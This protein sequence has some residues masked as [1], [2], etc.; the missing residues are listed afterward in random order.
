VIGGL[1]REDASDIQ[2]KP[3]VL[4]DLPLIGWMFQ[5][6][7]NKKDRS[8]IVIALIPRIVPFDPHYDDKNRN[9]YKRAV[10]PLLDCELKRLPRDD[11]YMLHDSWRNPR[12]LIWLPIRRL[13][14][15]D[16]P[17]WV[18]GEPVEQL[19]PSE[20]IGPPQPATSPLP[21]G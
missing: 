12:H 9:D 8:E 11:G 7:D 16:E 13:P 20:A 14:M 15:I 18:E 3:L 19:P 17:E 10:T 1:I 2:N 21:A 4:G 6:R 5:H